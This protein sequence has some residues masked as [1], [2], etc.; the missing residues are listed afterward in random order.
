MFNCQYCDCS[1]CL[2]HR[3][4]PKYE[5]VRGKV[6][7]WVYCGENLYV[8]L[9]GKGMNG[10]SVELELVDGNRITLQGPWMSNRKA[11]KADTG[12]VL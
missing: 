5:M 8:E 6:N 7:L 1:Q 2:Y 11:F 4:K 10:Q 12:I 3:D 9:D